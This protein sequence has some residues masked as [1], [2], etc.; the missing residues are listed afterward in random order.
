[1]GFA[2]TTRNCLRPMPPTY[3]TG[4]QPKDATKTYYQGFAG[5][6]TMFEPGQKIKLQ[7]IQDGTSNTIAVIEAGPPVEWSKPADI[8]YDPKKPLTKLEGP[9]A[10]VMHAA[11]GDGSR[12]AYPRVIPEKTLRYPDRAQRRECDPRSQQAAAPVP[13]DEGGGQ[14]RRGV[15]QEEREADRGDRPGT[16]RTAQDPGGAVQET[17][18]EGPHEGS[19][20]RDDRRALSRTR[21]RSRTP[22]EAD[23]GDAQGSATADSATAAAGAD[24]EVPPKPRP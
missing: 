10:N 18:P 5:P 9:F 4:I 15:H 17:R 8:P 2:I 11:H 16:A 12:R 7:D 20:S 6:G 1:M 21:G 13:A 24:A 22:Q 23:R 3:R 19:R 14:V